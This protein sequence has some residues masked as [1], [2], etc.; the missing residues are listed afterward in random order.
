MLQGMGSALEQAGQG[1]TA[2]LPGSTRHQA[3]PWGQAE[4]RPGHQCASGIRI[5]PGKVSQGQT[6]PWTAQQGRALT[7]VWCGGS[8]FTQN[9]RSRT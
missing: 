8:D 9:E 5:R 2:P 4:D 3:S 1:L 7:A 6:Q